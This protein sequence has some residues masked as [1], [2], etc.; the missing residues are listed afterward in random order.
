MTQSIDNPNRQT[1][2]IIPA[3]EKA[4]HRLVVASSVTSFIKWGVVA[5]GTGTRQFLITIRHRSLPRQSKCLL[6]T[7]HGLSGDGWIIC[8]TYVPLD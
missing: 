8:L 1:D 7:S 2:G 3:A 5:N 4:G 6:T